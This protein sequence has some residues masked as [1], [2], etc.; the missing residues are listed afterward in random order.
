MSLLT[1]IS[2]REGEAA[3][4]K[5]PALV[6]RMQGVLQTQFGYTTLK[7]IERCVREV[8]QNERQREGM[9]RLPLLSRLSLSPSLA[10]H[11]LGM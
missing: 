9:R 5:V 1:A 3:L 4:E 7:D 2:V 8:R 11:P 10:F 6:D